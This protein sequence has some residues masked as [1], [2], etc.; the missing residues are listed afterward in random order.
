MSIYKT[1][2]LL[3]LLMLSAVSAVKD[4]T[5]TDSQRPIVSYFSTNVVKIEKI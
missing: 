5:Q 3:V 2:K 4:W 1:E